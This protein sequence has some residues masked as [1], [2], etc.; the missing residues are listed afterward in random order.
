MAKLADCEAKLKSGVYSVVD[1]KM[2]RKPGHEEERVEGEEC[3]VGEGEATTS[4]FTV[5][6]D[7][8]NVV[9]SQTKLPV[10]AVQCQLSKKCLSYDVTGTRNSSLTN[11]ILNTCPVVK[12]KLKSPD[13][14]P[15]PP[16]SKSMF[17]D[18]LADMCAFT[19]SSMNHVTSEMFT[20]AAQFSK[21]ELV[22]DRGANIKKAL[23]DT[24]REDYNAHLLNTVVKGTMSYSHLELRKSALANSEK[25][26]DMCQ[27]LEEVARAAKSKSVKKNHRP[28]NVPFDVEKFTK[29]IEL[30]R[31]HL[32]QYASMMQSVISHQRKVSPVDI[33]ALFLLGIWR[34]IGRQACLAA[35]R[36]VYLPGAI[37]FMAWSTYSDLIWWTCLVLASFVATAITVTIKFC[38]QHAAHNL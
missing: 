30:L 10:G 33:R 5:W 17:V 12:G 19:L 6:R 34:P 32:F 13:F 38:F 8:K 2:L 24:D 36:A 22:T 25:A 7:L 1:R 27:K 16:G 4:K 31:A 18:N 15:V 26:M 20:T 28:L 14:V 37:D 9:D 21:I 3:E 29:I 35:W 11:H 23:E